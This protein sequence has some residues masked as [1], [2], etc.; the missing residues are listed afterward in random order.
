MA[1]LKLARA[2]ASHNPW[3]CHKPA[4]QP[5]DGIRHMIG[6]N[7]LFRLAYS[8]AHRMKDGIVCVYVLYGDDQSTSLIHVKESVETCD[9][10]NEWEQP[11][12]GYTTCYLRY[13]NTTAC[14]VPSNPMSLPLVDHDQLEQKKGVAQPAST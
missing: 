11:I 10:R 2:D 4:S 7:A 1:D 9:H 6:T 12:W 3:R 8:Q 13:R 14:H 5:L